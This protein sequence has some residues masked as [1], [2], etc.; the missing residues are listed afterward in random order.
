VDVPS[1]S[2]PNV[3]ATGALAVLKAERASV[4]AKA[5]QLETE[6]AP[7]RHVAEPIGADSDSEW[8]IR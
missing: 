3:N 8:A 1:R 6:A 7:I 5:R 2:T 4:T